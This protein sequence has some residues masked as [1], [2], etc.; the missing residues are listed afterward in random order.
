[1][2]PPAI[3]TEFTAVEPSA[4]AAIDIMQLC[5]LQSTMARG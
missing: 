5:E 2:K 1:V 4:D 3:A